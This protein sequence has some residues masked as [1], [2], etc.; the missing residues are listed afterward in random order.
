M[1]LF[2][3]SFESCANNFFLSKGGKKQL[4][5]FEVAQADQSTMSINCKTISLYSQYNISCAT[6][7][8][9]CFYRRGTNKCKQTDYN[10]LRPQLTYKD[11]L[12][13]CLRIGW[14]SAGFYNKSAGL[15]RR[16][17]VTT[18][19]RRRT[20]IQQRQQT[21]HHF[22]AATKTTTTTANFDYLPAHLSIYLALSLSLLSHFLVYLLARSPIA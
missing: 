3:C 10:T 11:C 18:G 6:L 9:A 13:R 5:Q 15:P 17:T 14:Q 22:A 20:I 16:L 2:S 7:F 21:M 12:L 1:R 4:C 8:R 19:C